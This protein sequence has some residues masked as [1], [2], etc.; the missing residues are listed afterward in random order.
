MPQPQQPVQ[1]DEDNDKT[2]DIKPNGQPEIFYGSIEKDPQ[3]D[4]L[5]GRNDADGAVIY[6]NDAVIYSN[7]QSPNDN[8]QTVAPSEQLYVNFGQ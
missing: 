8:S 3:S 6:T 5:H 2:T 4:E 7:L 1:N